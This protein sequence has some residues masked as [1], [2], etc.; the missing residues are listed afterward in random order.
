[1]CTKEGLEITYVIQVTG[2]ERNACSHPTHC[3]FFVDMYTE[4]WHKLI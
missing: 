2:H 3:L 1:M 4:C